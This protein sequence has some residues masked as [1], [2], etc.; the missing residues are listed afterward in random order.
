MDDAIKKDLDRASDLLDVA[1]KELTKRLEGGTGE[2]LKLAALVD[3]AVKVAE[4][5]GN[6]A[7]SRDAMAR[8]KD[9]S[10]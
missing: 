5:S 4:T 1:A 2:H 10:E 7:Y 8:R 3:A 9:T 6:V